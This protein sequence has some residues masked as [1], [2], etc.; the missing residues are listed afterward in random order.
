MVRPV[1]WRSSKSLAW[2]TKLQRTSR[3]AKEIVGRKSQSDGR[4]GRSKLLTYS[5]G[6]EQEAGLVAAFLAF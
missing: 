3:T 1:V 6:M 2:R 5:S 4:V